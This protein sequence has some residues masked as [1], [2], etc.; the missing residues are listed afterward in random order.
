MT[1]MIC[2]KQLD[3]LRCLLLR[4]RKLGRRDYRGVITNLNLDSRILRQLLKSSLCI[5]GWMC[6]SMEYRTRSIHLKGI[7]FRWCQRHGVRGDLLEQMLANFLIKDQK[8]H[9]LGLVATCSH[10]CCC[11]CSSSFHPFSSYLF[12][13]FLLIL[14]P[15]YCSSTLSL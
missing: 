9:I 13:S 4:Q 10:G 1:P 2:L 5:R 11:C 15:P 3:K 14:I 6:T 8:V 12:S 7:N